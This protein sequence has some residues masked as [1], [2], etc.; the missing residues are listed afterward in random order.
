MELFNTAEQDVR[1]LELARF[2]AM[3]EADPDTLARIFA[4]ELAYG[5]SD[6]GHDT[7]ASLIDK[8][9]SGHLDYLDIGNPDLK[10]AVVGETA[11]VT[12]RMVA[13]LRV[14]GATRHLNNRSLSVWAR[15]DR[16][17]LFLAFQPTVLPSA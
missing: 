2:R 1:D 13:R 7:K 11:I 4:D 10:V 6:G 16:R 3:I 15:S 14:G 12:G 9:A 5:H 17:W 8:I